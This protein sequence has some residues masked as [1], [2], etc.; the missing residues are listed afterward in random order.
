MLV[1]IVILVAVALAA[2][3]FS[4]TRVG[5]T[6]A[7]AVHWFTVTSIL[8]LAIIAWRLYALHIWSFE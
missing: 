3:Y 1:L 5:S 8:A 7:M 6:Q 2:G 4:V